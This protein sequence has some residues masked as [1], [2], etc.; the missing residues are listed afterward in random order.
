MKKGL[1]YLWFFGIFLC[2]WA[3][4][5]SAQ[6]DLDSAKYYLELSEFDIAAHYYEKWLN[7]HQPGNE[8]Y[9]NVMMNYAA[10][11]KLQTKYGE[12]LKLYEEIKNGRFGDLNRRQEIAIRVGMGELFRT[13]DK[14]DRSLKELLSISLTQADLRKYPKECAAIY[15]RLAASYN[16]KGILDSAVYYSQA[17]M[18]ISRDH[19]LDNYMSISFNEIANIFEKNQMIDSA[20]FYY[21]QAC[22]FWKEKGALR[23]YANAF[24]NRA[25][26]TYHEGKLDS[27]RWLFEQNLKSVENRNWPEVTGPIYHYL[28]QIYYAKGDSMKALKY[29]LKNMQDNLSMLRKSQDRN[30]LDMEAKYKSKEKDRELKYHQLEIERKERELDERNERLFLLFVSLLL[31]VSI[32]VLIAIFAIRFR[33]NNHKLLK[34]LKENEFLLAES[35]HRIKNNLQLITS[36]IMQETDKYSGND[37]KILLEL[38]NKIESISMLHKQI[39][40]EE[41]KEEIDLKTYFLGIK[42]NYETFCKEKH[43]ACEL[44]LETVY[45]SIDKSLYLGL[46]LSE[47]ISNSLKHAFSSTKEPKILLKLKAENEKVYLE[48]WDN[49]S[50]LKEHTPTLVELMCMQ[51]KGKYTIASENGFKLN[52]QIKK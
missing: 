17:S 38:S 47:L 43:V 41:S 13:I 35:N 46:L 36:L 26:V 34:L 24:F 51:L 4:S 22:A 8:E 14:V 5:S 50:G 23:L 40:L 3:Q 20:K 28:T 44:E 18:K 30:L 33:R 19:N 32:L 37:R 25:R 45:A 10:N 2:A 48:Y 42:E 15:H 52:L 39:Y 29:E 16:Q 12:S 1:K 31:A 9:I 11:V 49:G 7:Q 27:A 6:S 21:D